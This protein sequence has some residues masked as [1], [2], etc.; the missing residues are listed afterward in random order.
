M[1]Y[2][3][4]IGIESSSGSLV[5]L[6]YGVAELCGRFFCAIFAGHIKFSLSYMYTVCSLLAGIVALITPNYKTISMLYFY[7]ICEFSLGARRSVSFDGGGFFFSTG[8]KAQTGTY[9]RK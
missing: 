5:L 2:M 6:A 8:C 1:D 3:Q 9:V 4:T 7:G